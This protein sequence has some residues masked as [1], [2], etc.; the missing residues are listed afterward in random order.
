MPTA[1]INGVQ[2]NYV[3]LDE[4]DGVAREDLIMVHG[5]ATNMAS[6]TSST[7]WRCPSVSG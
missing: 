5:L 7:V 1:L 3:Q 4:G 6:G 2:L